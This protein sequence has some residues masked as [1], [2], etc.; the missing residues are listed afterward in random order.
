MLPPKALSAARETMMSTLDITLLKGEI[1]KDGIW[2]PN[3][4]EERYC[5]RNIN[6]RKHLTYGRRYGMAAHI[7]SKGHLARKYGITVKQLKEA[8]I[9]VKV[10]QALEG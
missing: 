9:V 6:R 5:C 4:D 8:I 10:M 7:Q 1:N 2:W 3:P